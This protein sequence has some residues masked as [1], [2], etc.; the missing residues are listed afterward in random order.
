MHELAQFLTDPRPVESGLAG[1]KNGLT[2]PPSAAADA[3]L[4]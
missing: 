3:Q 2:P 4:G 1:N